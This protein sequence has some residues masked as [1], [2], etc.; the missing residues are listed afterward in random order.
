MRHNCLQGKEKLLNMLTEMGAGEFSD[1]TG[2]KLRPAVVVQ[3]DFLNQSIDDT[4]VV[5]I[6]ARSRSA[7][8]E[9]VLDPAVETNASLLGP[10]WPLHP[11]G[12]RGCC[13]ACRDRSEGA[14]PCRPADQAILRYRS[15][16]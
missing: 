16:G 10:A 8:T 5:S 13:R 6:T 9:V 12:G 7:L 14:A 1:G 2:S 3:A 15:P 4:V 11:S